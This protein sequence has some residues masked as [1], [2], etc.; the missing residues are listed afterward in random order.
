[1]YN[2]DYFLD[3]IKH[4]FKKKTKC[5]RDSSIMMS[6]TIGFVALNATALHIFDNSSRYVILLMSYDIDYI[7]V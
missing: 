3:E 5:I 6:I 1:M 7:I 2:Y 4:S